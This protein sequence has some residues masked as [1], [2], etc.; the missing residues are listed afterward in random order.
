[1]SEELKQ[2][3]L[4]LPWFDVIF[5]GE[6]IHDLAERVALRQQSPHPGRAG[7]I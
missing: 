6:C 2:I 7:V 3:V 1:V 4:K 5:R